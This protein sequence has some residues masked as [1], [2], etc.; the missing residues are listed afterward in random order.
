MIGLILNDTEMIGENLVI[1]IHSLVG[2]GIGFAIVSIVMHYYRRYRWAQMR[3]AG[4][5]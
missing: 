4:Q 2:I 5:G 3:R 1:C